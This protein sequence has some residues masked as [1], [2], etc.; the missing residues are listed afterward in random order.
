MSRSLA[1]LVLAAVAALAFPAW[2]KPPA[3]CSLGPI[4]DQDLQVSIG[5]TVIAMPLVTLRQGGGMS[6]GEEGQEGYEKFDGWRLEM[7][8]AEEYADTLE[9]HVY[10]LVR[11][12]EKLD[13]RSF[14]ELPD[15]KTGEQPA[16]T[17]GTP[18]IQGWGVKEEDSGLR[19]NGVGIVAGLRVEFGQRRGDVLPGRIQLCV[20]L[21]QPDKFFGD[22]VTAPVRLVGRFE[23]KIQP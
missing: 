8:G 12:G 7:T 15:K 11:A 23:A 6:S 16:V 1:M 22:S 19:I 17:E 13:G 5:T 3:D 2:S 18:E 20:P 21:A 14:R 9:A 4:P 10:V